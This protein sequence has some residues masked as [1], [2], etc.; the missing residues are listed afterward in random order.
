MV[1]SAANQ[2]SLPNSVACNES[3]SAVESCCLQRTSFRCQKC[4]VC[5]ELVFV[6]E[7]V[8][9]AANEFSVPNRV[10]SSE[11]VFVAELYCLQ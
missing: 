5:S 7:T 8:L 10:V 9:S 2:V 3:I 1:V 11:S 6:A 4:V